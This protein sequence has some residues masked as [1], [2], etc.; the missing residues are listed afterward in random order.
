MFKITKNYSQ[1]VKNFKISRSYLEEGSKTYVYRYDGLTKSIQLSEPILIPAN[2]NFKLN[3]TLSGG[4]TTLEGL[5]EGSGFFLR[6]LT[7]ADITFFNE[8]AQMNIAGL[9]FALLTLVNGYT[10]DGT[11]KKISIFRDNGAIYSKINDE[12]YRLD[13]SSADGAFSIDTLC[14]VGQSYFAGLFYDFEVEIDGAVT[15]RIPLTNKTQGA[16][17]LPTVGNVSATIINYTDTWEEV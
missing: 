3:F 5:M 6:L 16:T 11:V 10:R 15:N 12:D 17:Q 8:N 9:T 7:D 13:R 1:V 4:G 2:T 14:L